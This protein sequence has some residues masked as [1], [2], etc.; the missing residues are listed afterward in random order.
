MADTPSFRRQELISRLRDY[1]GDLSEESHTTLSRSIDRAKAR[2]EESPVHAIIMEAL[3]DIFRDGDR[4]VPR[5]PSAERAFFAPLEPIILPVPLPEKQAARV[6]R[7]SLHPIWVWITR[8]LAPGRCDSQLA[9]LRA[10]VADEDNAATE[11]CAND[12]RMVVCREAKVIIETMERKSGSLQK[13]EGQLGSGRILADLHDILA[14]F[15]HYDV[16]SDFLA[17]MPKTLPVGQKGLQVLAD[18][19]KVYDDAPDADPTYAYAAIV[20][21]IGSPSDL[22]RFAV[23]QARSSNPAIIRQSSRV[24]SAVQIALSEAMLDVQR[25]REQ[26]SGPRDLERSVACLRRYNKSVCTIA[27]TLDEVATDPWLRRLASIRAAASELLT[28]EFEPLV[29]L[30]KRVIGVVEARGRQITPDAGSIEEAVFGTT[31]FVTARDARSSLAVNALIDQVERGIDD[32][33]ENQGKSAVDRLA[34]ADD[35]SWEAALARSEAAVKLFEIYHR[36]V[37]GD[38]MARRHA[39]TVETRA[40]MARAS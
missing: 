34:A 3:R 15:D 5:F 12:L 30:I 24:S 20:G 23:M 33:L 14:F 9:A 2:G 13:L 32:A 29:H 11:E 39:S 27:R 18:A 28:K 37:Y 36:G 17:R 31:L 38:S 4:T 21:Q 25:L 19:L 10:A 26:L 6:D 22:V 8:D 40:L 16:L 1:L 7:G 35:D